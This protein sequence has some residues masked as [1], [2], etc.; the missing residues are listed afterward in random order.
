MTQ[1]LLET[2]WYQRYRPTTLSE[3]ILPPRLRTEMEEYVKRQGDTDLVLYGSTG[4]GK[5]TT[6]RAMLN[7]MGAD[8]MVINGSLDLGKDK[9]RTDVQN[10]ASTVSIASDAK[11]KFI[12]VEEADFMTG[13]QNG[14]QPALRA[15]MEQFSSNC[16]FIFTC[17][18]P[19][20]IMKELRGR[21]PE[22]NFKLNSEDTKYVASEY[23]KFVTNILDTENVQYEREAVIQV[24]KKTFPDLRKCINDLQRYSRQGKIDSGIFANDDADY[25]E[26]Y[27]TLK[28][29]DFNGMRR[30]VG[31]NSNIEAHVIFRKLYDD[32]SKLVT[33][34]SIP[35]LILHIAEAQF[36]SA[37]GLPDQEINTAALMINIMT[38][39]QFI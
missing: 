29:K 16:G 5:S 18:Y 28:A 15:F 14:V 26:L 24:I 35:I 10:F 20:K 22:I 27:K 21:S 1:N 37:L 38:E 32:L 13:G 39:V 33:A 3:V 7:D 4:V 8:F 11:R 23:L 31:L 36:R 12:L 9:L 25:K 17:N 34:P 2:V 19:N 6:A 30:W